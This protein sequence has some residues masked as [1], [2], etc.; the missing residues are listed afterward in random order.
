VSL[1]YRSGG[2]INSD[3]EALLLFEIWLDVVF[4]DL[5]TGQLQRDPGTPSVATCGFPSSDEPRNLAPFVL[6][7]RLFYSRLVAFYIECLA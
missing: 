4:R 7:A 2:G 3:S 6:S 1:V 5:Y